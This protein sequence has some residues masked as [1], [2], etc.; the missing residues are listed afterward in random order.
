MPSG[1]RA[2]A[3]EETVAAHQSRAVSCMAEPEYSAGA[4]QVALRAESAFTGLCHFRTFP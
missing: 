1:P 4:T 3:A 2:R